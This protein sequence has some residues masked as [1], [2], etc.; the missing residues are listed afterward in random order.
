[1]IFIF[2]G[3]AIFILLLIIG[4]TIQGKQREHPLLRALLDAGI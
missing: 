1:M 3:L 4:V 2:A